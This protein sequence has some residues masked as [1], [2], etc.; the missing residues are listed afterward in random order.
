MP[1]FGERVEEEQKFRKKS[2]NKNNLM[3]F[4]NGSAGRNN[5]KL[6]RI[7]TAFDLA[8]GILGW[9][10][11]PLAKFSTFVTQ[12]QASIEAKYHNDFKEVLVAEEIERR[13]EERKGVS[14]LQQ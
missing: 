1:T 9:Q 3:F 2:D 7:L 12:Y 13:K 6:A 14:I 5:E 10:N 11:K 8:I 4:T